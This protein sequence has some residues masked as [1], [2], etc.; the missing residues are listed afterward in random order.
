MYSV[1]SDNVY[2]ALAGLLCAENFL[3]AVMA[4]AL[5]VLCQRLLLLLM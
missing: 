2:M 1:G 3:M 5:A 4:A